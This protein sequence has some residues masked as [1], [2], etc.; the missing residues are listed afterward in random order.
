MLYLA[1]KSDSYMINEDFI[2][3]NKV[4][5]NLNNHR[6]HIYNLNWGLFGSKKKCSLCFKMN[7]W[8]ML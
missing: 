8:F 7:V 4:H 1:L 5:F 3:Q 6:L 2:L